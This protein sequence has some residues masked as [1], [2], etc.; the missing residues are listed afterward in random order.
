MLTIDAS[1]AIAALNAMAMRMANTEP[2]L[3]AIGYA[4]T[5][6]I[7]ARI[8]EGKTTPEGQQ[9]APWRPWTRE[10]RENKGNESQGLLW[11]TGTLLNSI[12]HQTD[13]RSVVIGTDVEYAHELQVGRGGPYPMV[14]RP[15][16]GWNEE[17]AAH[18]EMLM[19]HHIQGFSS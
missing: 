2:V 14:A 16:I 8:E 10:E 1:E 13:A 9:W 12:R 4:E 15:F 5:E 3:A 11:D 6:V 7:R 19:L 17:G 18:A